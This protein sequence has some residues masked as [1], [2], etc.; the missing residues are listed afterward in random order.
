MLSIIAILTRASVNLAPVYEA[1]V[2]ILAKTKTHG[3][4]VIVL[5]QTGLLDLL[6]TCMIP[7]KHYGDILCVPSVGFLSVGAWSP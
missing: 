1:R 7:Y 4:N 3:V 5:S 6:D 2:D